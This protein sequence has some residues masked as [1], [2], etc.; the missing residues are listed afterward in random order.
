VTLVKGA[1]AAGFNPALLSDLTNTAISRSVPFGGSVA[2][3]DTASQAAFLLAR[4]IL[5]GLLSVFFFLVAI[6]F[7][8]RR[9]KDDE[10]VH[11]TPYWML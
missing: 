3:A 4:T 1:Y 7:A 2:G 11:S 8:R 10:R 5:F 9:K 6:L